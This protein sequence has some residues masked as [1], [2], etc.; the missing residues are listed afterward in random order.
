VENIRF[1]D[2]A[3]LVVS[4]ANVTVRRVE[5]QGG[6]IYNWPGATCYNGL[7]IEDTSFMRLEGQP[8]AGYPEGA[9]GVGGYTARGV[10]IEDYSEGF[11]VGGNPD[12]GPVVIENSYIGI[13][14][15]QPCGDW[16]GDGIQGF[17]GGTLTVRNVTIDFDETGCGGTAPFFYPSGQGNTS[18]NIDR[19]LVKGGGYSFRNGMPGTVKGLRIVD[20][21]WY[22]GPIDVKC[23]AI[24]SWEAAIVTIDTAYR[25]RTVRAQPCNSNGG[26]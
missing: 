16:H 11:R 22:Y 17:H 18:V 4:A 3:D 24:T 15:P 19:L 10:S 21:S 12:C 23:S 20:G 13:V 2:G 8:S 9:V 26:A 7:V 6:S 5:F 25:A 1:A 14:P